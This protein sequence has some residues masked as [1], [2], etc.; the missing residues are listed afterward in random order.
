M[1]HADHAL[2]NPATAP[3]RTPGQADGLGGHQLAGVV[4]SQ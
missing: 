3:R 2:V 1:I 4:S